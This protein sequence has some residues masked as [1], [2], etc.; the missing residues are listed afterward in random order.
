MTNRL[1]YITVAATALIFTLYHAVLTS[2]VIARMD[3]YDFS[4]GYILVVEIIAFLPLAVGMLGVM[5][6][7]KNHSELF[8]SL[9]YSV[10]I[11]HILIAAILFTIHSFWQ[12]YINAVFFNDEFIMSLFTKDFITFLEMRFLVYVIFVGLVSGLIKIRE[13][14]EIVVKESELNLKLQR[15]RLKELELKMNPEI[16]YPNL[17]FIKEKATENPEEASQM[18]I[19]MAGILRRLVDNMEDEKVKVVDEANFFQMYIDLIKLRLKRPLEVKINIDKSIMSEK[20]PSMILIIPLF[21]KL[22]FGEYSDYFSK[23]DEFAFS[24]LKISEDKLEEIILIKNL[25]SIDSLSIKLQDE[26]LINQI[27]SQLIDLAKGE[28]TFKVKLKDTELAL[29][30]VSSKRENE[31]ANV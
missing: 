1:E 3:S 9:S 5:W 26:R 15:A 31:T 16:I 2:L 12:P 18:V 10:V 6:L 25:R 17:G 22:F 14:Q 21:E 11:K 13:Q 7:G 8:T 4:F 23:V 28:F 29:R 30:L 24:V 19:L 27:N 20:V